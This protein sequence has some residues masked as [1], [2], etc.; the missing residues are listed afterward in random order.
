MMT[1]VTG[2]IR[3]TRVTGAS[4]DGKGGGEEGEGRGGREDVTIAGHRTNEQG[5]IG[6][7]SQLTMEGRWYE[8]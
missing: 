7:L 6:L 8:Q 2:V 4:K 5:K 3:A 1:G